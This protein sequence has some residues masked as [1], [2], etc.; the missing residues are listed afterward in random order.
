MKISTGREETTEKGRKIL[1]KRGIISHVLSTMQRVNLSQIPHCRLLVLHCREEK[2]GETF[3]CMIS[4]KL[5]LADLVTMEG[6]AKM[7]RPRHSPCTQY[8]WNGTPILCPGFSRWAFQYHSYSTMNRIKL[9]S[10]YQY[11]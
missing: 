10:M 11:F 9:P 3:S 5:A 2:R 1:R 8:N 4:G 7:P 6:L